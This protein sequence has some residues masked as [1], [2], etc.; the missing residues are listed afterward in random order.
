MAHFHSVT[1]IT[2][3]QVSKSMLVEYRFSQNIYP[4]TA[5]ILPIGKK[6]KCQNEKI[7]IIL[8][9]IGKLTSTCHL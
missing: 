1:Q 5:T 4:T 8:N 3:P 2:Q 6:K 7:I 9:D